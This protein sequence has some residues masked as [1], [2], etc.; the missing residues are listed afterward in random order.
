MALGGLSCSAGGGSDADR[1]PQATAAST[2][3]P[4]A[5]VAVSR[6]PGAPRIEVRDGFRA[7]VYAR[8]VQTPTA[9]AFG[10]DGRLYVT[11][12]DGKIVSVGRGARRAR[13]LASGFPTPL[14][15]AWRNRTLY[16]SAQGRV[17][18]AAN[19][20]REGD[21]QADDPGE[22]PLRTASTGH[23]RLRAGRSALS[24]E[25]IDLR[26]VYRAGRT[27]RRR[28]LIPVRMAPISAS[29]R[30]ASEIP[31]DSRSSRGPAVSTSR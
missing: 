3:T 5:P 23:D 4:S 15:L 16:V 12:E 14:G 22:P 17:E 29:S 1:P 13:L 28:A 18:Q 7:E 19:R 6:L 27:E 26:R 30:P 11:Q 31:S 2:P 10:P 24:R 25:R 21:S 8:G 20:R 9:M